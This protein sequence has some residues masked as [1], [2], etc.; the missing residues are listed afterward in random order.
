MIT[1]IKF[2]TY[3]VNQF[4]ITLFLFQRECPIHF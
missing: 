3:I 4:T 2:K 1:K